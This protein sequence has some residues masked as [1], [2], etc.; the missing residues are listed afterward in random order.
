MQLK[1]R[2]TLS[3]PSIVG[4]KGCLQVLNPPLSNDEQYWPEEMHRDIVQS[5][6]T[7][8]LTTPIGPMRSAYMIAR[9]QGVGIQDSYIP[10]Q[11]VMHSGFFTSGL[12]SPTN[13]LRF[14]ILI[15]ES[16]FASSVESAGNRPLRL[17][18]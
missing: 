7:N 1:N 16:V 10:P 13:L 2:A 3:L 14:G 6:G 8:S 4:R 15:A 11:R 9:S 12:A 17:R 18:I 5:P